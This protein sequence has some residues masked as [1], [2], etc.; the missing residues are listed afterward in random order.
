MQNLP[1]R[2]F[3]FWYPDALFVFT[4]V[5]HNLL[6]IIEEDLAVGL[7]LKLLFVPLFHDSSIVGRALSFLFRV[8]RVITGL[9]GYFFAS[10]GMII[11]ALL[12]FSSPILAIIPN[13]TIPSIFFKVMFL[14]GLTTF[15]DQVA[16]HPKLKVKQIN[17]SADVWMATKLTKL[18]ISFDRLTQTKEVENLLFYLETTSQNLPSFNAPISDELLNLVVAL[19]K[20]NKAKYVTSAYFWVAELLDIP[21]IDNLLLKLDLTTDDIKGALNFLE[22]RRQKWGKVYIWDEEFAVSHLRGVNRGWLGAP[23]PALDSVC[24]DLTANAAKGFSDNFAGREKQVSEIVNILSQDTNQNVVVVGPAGS[25]KTTLVN[26]LAKRIIAGDAPE[27]LATKRLVSLDLAR[28]LSGVTS[29]GQLAERIDQVFQEVKTIENIIIY[30]DEIQNL[31]LGEAASNY[32]LYSLMLPHLE[33]DKIQFLSSTEPENYAKILEKN[34]AFARLFT[35]VELPP[36]SIDET[37]SILLNLSIELEK[38][39]KI[40]TT[41]LAMKTLAELSSKLIHDRVLPDSAL[42]SFNE[43]ITLAMDGKITTQIIKEVL[44]RRVNVPLE[45]VGTA[46]KEE[47]LNLEDKIH[48]K[49]INQQ[50]AVKAVADTLRRAAVSLREQ[51]RPIGS[52]LFVGPTGVGKTELAKTLAEVY[53]SAGP[54]SSQPHSTSSTSLRGLNEAPRSLSPANSGYF[55]R[56]DMSEYQN[57]NAVDRLIGNL[58][59]PGELTEAIRNK[60]YALILLDEFEKADPQILNLFLQVLDDGRLTDASGKTVDFTNTIIIATSNAASL[61]IAQG[62]E[63]GQ[64]LD[65]LNMLVKEELLKVFRPELVNRFDEIVIFK[66]LSHQDLEKI[67]NLKLTDLAKMLKDQGY[68]VEFSPE[69]VDELAKKGFDPVLGA[70]PMRRLIQDSLEA[71][72]SRMILENKLTKGELF[73]VSAELLN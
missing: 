28:L 15:A 39:K 27:S 46:Q 31:G 14:F 71:R 66:P 43:A 24:E 57:Q 42:A 19:T 47:L 56:F 16:Y 8:T 52:F 32:N 21:L 49:M 37:L 1:K 23:T 51:T 6:S 4:R 59:N 26:F 2:L 17:L 5:W 10:L 68:L 69:L 11:F 22:Q 61:M 25:G 53:F 45:A 33:S 65:Q 72:L 20:A 7:M 70:R 12:W 18:D 38:S 9:I 50:Q 58:D 73:K 54:A 35:K 13:F 34:A 64:N 36:A 3:N 48:T 44:G 55:I 30:V 63:R 41:Y 29:Q 60:P 40:Q 62:L 67:V